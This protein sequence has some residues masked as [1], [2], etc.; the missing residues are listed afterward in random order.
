M[1]HHQDL[2]SFH[3]SSNFTTRPKANHMVFVGNPG[4]GKT[5]VARLLAK[6]LFELGILRKPKFLECERMDLVSRDSRNTIAKTQEVLQE[7]RGGVLFIDEAYSLGLGT[8]SQCDTSQDAIA[9]LI[10][11]MDEAEKDHPLIIIAG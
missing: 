5:S 1:N 4:T 10:R 2:T 11:S 3:S 9:D 6:A 7:A 8:R